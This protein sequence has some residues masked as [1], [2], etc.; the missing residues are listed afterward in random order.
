MPFVPTVSATD[1]IARWERMKQDRQVWLTLWDPVALYCCPRKGNILTKL[2]PGQQQTI[3]VYDTTAQDAGGIF[4]AGCV[5]HICPAGEKW[6]RLEPKGPNPSPTV[7]EWYDRATDKLMDAIYGSNFYEGIHETF[8]SA[9]HFGNSLLFEDEDPVEI[10]NFAEIPV[11][12]FAWEEDCRGRVS[13]VA[14]EWQWTAK[15]AEEKWGRA[16][17]GKQQVEALVDGSPAATTRKFNYI[18][19]VEPRENAPKLEGD[20]AAHL[21]PFRGVYICIEDQQVVDEGGYYTMP[22]F[23]NRLL[24]SNDEA[25]G[26]GPGTDKLPDIRMVN[27]MMRD[28][29]VNV[30]KL[31]SPGWLLGDDTSA[32]LDNRPNGESYWDT[33]AGE[34]G[35]PEQLTL[36][37]NVKW[38]K[39]MID[40]VREIIKRGYYNDLFQMLTNLEESKREKTAYEVQQMVAEKLLLFSPLFG[41]ITKEVLG[42]A[43]TRSFDI[44]C[45][46]SHAAWARGEDGILP[47]PPPELAQNPGYNI[48]Y[49][50]KIAL[51]IKAAEN[52]AFATMMTLVEQ[53]SAIDP[54]ARYIIDIP[55]GLRRVGR[56]VGTPAKLIRSERDVE[57]MM[58]AD[59]QAAAA[60]QAP[61]AAE[62]AARAAKNLGPQAQTAAARKIIS[63]Q[64]QPAAA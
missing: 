26:R 42:P 60:Q 4:S 24:R 48:V 39:E 33:S 18:H 40:E 28:Y 49:V 37:N 46:A 34:L 6:Q 3:N 13:R 38:A 43:L 45:R 35:K 22:Y 41:R 56:N 19:L 51:A 54:R 32:D 59:Q 57:K 62:L 9:G 27:S 14:R 15:Q 47:L 20:K 7:S 63:S 64:E 50:S 8:T 21:R 29:L 2:T 1:I 36:K 30:E 52:Q 53:A 23:G 55:G 12:K 16:A 44:M 25:Y 11:G 58:Q 61:E 5:T 17:L 10:F 31:S